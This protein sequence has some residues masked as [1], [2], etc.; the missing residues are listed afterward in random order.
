[1][2]ALALQ[3]KAVPTVP[4]DTMTGSALAL[5]LFDVGEE[6]RI[7]E[8]RQAS[9]V[10]QA[11]G[12]LK[13]PTPQYVGFRRPLLV[14]DFGE[15]TPT[16]G[17]C[18]RTRMKFFD[19]GVVSILFEMPFAGDW[20]GWIELAARWMASGEFERLGYELARA[21]MD[22]L[23]SAVVKPYAQWLSEDY[24]IFHA[25]EIPGSPTASDLITQCSDQIAQVVRGETC[26]LSQSEKNEILQAQLSYF[27][28]DLAVIG[29]HGAFV[30]D[31]PSGAQATIELLEHSNSQLL[32][33]RHYD[34]WLTRELEAGYKFLERE[35]SMVRRWR[36][37][38]EGA[39]LQRVTLEITELSERTENAIKFLSDMFSARLYNLAAAKI[40]VND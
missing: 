18:L 12:A 24:F 4:A 8:L 11:D 27:P 7:G 38:R 39:R 2:R 17:E 28:R 34:D 15:H 40:G 14:Q 6:L 20:D 13:H 37:A 3:W 32:E 10:R 29:W 16:S 1:M 30:Y 21:E 19:Y 5:M 36:L 9:G 35:S 26:R 31:S 33:F 23:G 25:A 22:H